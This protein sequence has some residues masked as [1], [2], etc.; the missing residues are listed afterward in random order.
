LAVPR[1]VDQDQ[2]RA[3]IAEALWRVAAGEGLEAV[4]LARVAREA[5]V[6]KGR[7]QHYFASRDELLA[8]AGRRLVARVRGRVADRL[9]AAGP[10]LAPAEH[11][12]VLLRG[13]LPLDET[14]RVDARVRSAFL[15]RALGDPALVREYQEGNRLLVTAVTG[16]LQIHGVTEPDASQEARLLVA[17]VEGLETAVLLEE[18]TP[19]SATALVDHQIA[20]AFGHTGQ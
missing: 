10:T 9:A 7:V 5:G 12:R 17:L 19:A 6:S 20:R 1:I 18:E 11:V 14:S 2:R 15:V 16:C 8:D 3:A 4:S 13:V